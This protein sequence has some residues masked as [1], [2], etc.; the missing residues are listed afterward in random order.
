MAK[1]SKLW[2]LSA[3]VLLIGLIGSSLFQRSEARTGA[4]RKAARAEATDLPATALE[5]SQ[6]GMSAAVAEAVKAAAE[7]AKELEPMR[8]RIREVVGTFTELARAHLYEGTFGRSYRQECTALES[9]RCKELFTGAAYEALAWH[10][11]PAILAGELGAGELSAMDTAVVHAEVIE[12]LEHSTD[13]LE[14][15]CTLELLKRSTKLRPIAFPSEVYRDLRAKPVIEANLLLT[16][17]AMTGLPDEATT[18][19]VAAL[20]SAAKI[21]P[22]VQGRALISLAT[23]STAALLKEAVHTLTATHDPEWSGW[24][25]DVAP[26]LGRCGAACSDVM[27]EVVAGA[28]DSERLAVQILHLTRPRDRGELLTR[29]SPAL[30]PQ[31]IAQLKESMEI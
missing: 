11:D 31:V 27:I 23:P 5:D 3:L 12:L 4:A 8:K 9:E 26:A 29:L 30:S 18:Q 22:R 1:R 13:P 24:S 21:D 25:A 6:R 10:V 17:S 14:R 15:V 2:F 20:A 7:R 28:A 16:P 19:E